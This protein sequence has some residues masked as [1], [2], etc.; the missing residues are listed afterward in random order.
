MTLANFRYKDTKM[1]VTAIKFPDLNWIYLVL[2]VAQWTDFVNMGFLQYC[3][4]DATP[5][6]LVNG[7][8]SFGGACCCIF[9][10]QED[11]DV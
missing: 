5:C 8:G 3:Y 10:I 4:W 1:D 11:Y 6:R 9:S 7:Y 2:E